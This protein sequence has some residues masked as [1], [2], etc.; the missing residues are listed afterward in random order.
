MIATGAAFS[1]YRAAIERELRSGLAT[2]HTYRPALKSLIEALGQASATNEPKRA[3]C[4]APDYTVWRPDGHGPMTIG[5]IEAKDIGYSLDAAERSEQLRRYLP[6]LDNLILTDYLEFRWYLKGERRR[7][8]RL[9][10]PKA[11]GSLTRAEG[12]ELAVE[13]LIKDF[14]AQQ[15]GVIRKPLELADRMARLTRLIRDVILASFDAGA[16]SQPVLDLRTAFSEV[17]VPD[18]S[19]QAFADMFAQTI[20]YGLF[21]ARVNHTDGAFFRRHDAVYEIPRTNPFLR[22][23]FGAIAGSDLDQEPYAG[24]VDD[25]TSLLAITDMDAVLANFGS[26]V[27]LEDPVVHFYETFLAAYDPA[28]RET[29]GVYY[30]PE[31]IVSFI[32]RSVDLLLREQFGCRDGFA[33]L[34]RL[35]HPGSASQAENKRV[36]ILDPACGTGTFL[37][38]IIDLIRNRF[39][40]AKDAGKWSGYVREQLL[41]RLFGFE[42]LMAPYAVAHLK[43]GLQLAAHDL[44]E[45]ERDDW[46]YDFASDERVGVFLTNTLDEAI[47][48]SDIMLGSYLSDEANAAADIKHDLPIMVVLGNP[49]YSGASSNRGD[50]IE[51]LMEN[52][53]TTV[54]SEERQIQRLSNDYVKFIRFAQWRVERTGQGIVAFVT[55]HGYLANVLFRDMRASLLGTF[56][57]VFI[58]NLHGVAVRGAANAGPDENVFDITQG[59]AIS[60]FVKREGGPTTTTIH[61]ADLKGSR[62]TKYELLTALDL[63]TVKWEKLSPQPPHWRLVP[64]TDDESYEAW[65]S[66]ISLIGTGDQRRDRDRRYGT[67]VKSRHDKLVISWEPKDAVANVQRLANR[68]E[69][70]ADLTRELHLCTTSHFNIDRARRRAEDADLPEHVRPLAYR[71]FDERFIVY[72]REFV[73]E[74]K[75]ETMRHL[76]LEDNLALAVLRRDRR[77]RASG[78]M[79]ARGL[80]GK[81]LISNL[82]D[83]LVWPLYVQTST[84][85]E[86]QLQMDE[87]REAEITPNLSTEAIEKFATALELSFIPHGRGDCSETFGPED[88]LSY[89]YAVLHA[90]SYRTRYHEFLC[91]DFP[92]IPIPEDVDAF[93]QL[94]HL[95]RQLVELHLLTSPLLFKPT[96][97]YPIP[98]SD[99]VAPG[100]PRYTPPGCDAEAEGDAVAAGQVY[101]NNDQY[102]DNVPPAVWDFHIGAYQVCE[103][104][105]KDRRGRRLSNAE[106][107]HYERIVVAL[108]ETVRVMGQIDELSRIWREEPTPVA[109]QLYLDLLTSLRSE[110][111]VPAAASVIPAEVGRHSSD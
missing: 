24:L 79:V 63:K 95:G 44:P 41:P 99:E 59:V 85:G 74:P 80:I 78:Y 57:D 23:L 93:G 62:A 104:W 35:G 102:F 81:D 15:P 110:H 87:L 58:L 10:S 83:A 67:G 75:K 68:T 66:F 72:L 26:R 97:H 21:A 86:R 64:T 28:L 27:G 69:T 54:R 88:I 106:I 103:K 7:T 70:N 16:V 18:L 4:G 53:K 20:A 38:S 90:P 50:W 101:I 42:L 39:R 56:S 71:P 49:P 29:R 2:E 94:V 25:L 65:P 8:E 55:D 37:Y 84:P 14:L 31:P 22:R 98:G 73:C 105:L 34:T 60:I 45:D 3:A 36:L 111:Q 76:L 82:D 92:H 11:D 6:A 47:K 108:S 13:E 91:H 43:L 96:I 61:Y 52:Y 109:D 17:L 107:T 5:Y 89:F 1:E 30:T 40:A 48:R 46:A 77:E 12:G 100:Y 32:V 33:E 19:V 51:A 9:A